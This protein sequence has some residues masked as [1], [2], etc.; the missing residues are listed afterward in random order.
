MVDVIPEPRDAVVHGDGFFELDARTG[1]SA[2]EGAAPTE[3]WLR[4]TLG[5]ATGLPLPPGARADDNVVRR[6]VEPAGA[7]GPAAGGL[8]PAGAPPRGA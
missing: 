1:L 6:S 5:A 4:T 3:R 7:P 2:G 8:P